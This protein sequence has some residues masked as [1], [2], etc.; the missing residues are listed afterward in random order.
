MRHF[1]ADPAIVGKPLR[2]SG[3][4][5]TIVG[6]APAGRLWPE[7]RDVWRPM[8]PALLDDDTKMRRDNMVFLSIARVRTDVP[9][10]QAKARIAT[11]GERVGAGTS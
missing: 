6:V 4:V 11:I 9:F 10:A 1:G 8:R 3:Q 7:K 2:L 5:V